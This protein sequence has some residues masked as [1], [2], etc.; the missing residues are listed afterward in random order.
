MSQR[1]DRVARLV[2]RELGDIL[3]SEVKD[4]RVTDAGL[5]TVTHVRVSDD[6]SVAR[7]FVT[8]HGADEVR[9]EAAL[10]GLASAAP[11]MRRSLGRRLEAKRIPELRFQLDDTEERAG[12]VE[13]LLREIH[14]RGDRDDKDG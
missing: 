2:Q 14:A 7:V 5:L 9:L 11:H 4:P 8:V 12:R 10:K 13:E 6:L 1:A 3:S